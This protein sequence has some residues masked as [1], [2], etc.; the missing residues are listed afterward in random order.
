[1]KWSAPAINPKDVHIAVVDDEPIIQETIAAY[2]KNE[3]YKVSTADGATELRRLMDRR[4]FD[5]VLLDIRLSDGDGLSLMRD[6][7]A[8]SDIPVILVTSKSDETDRVIGLELGA[9]DYITK[10]FSPRE[11]LARV[12]TVLRRL[13]RAPEDPRPAAL[14]RFAGWSLHV[15][16]RRLT[17]PD[18]EQVR[19]TL[20]EFD[21]LSALV[22]HPGRVM[23][24][25]DLVETIGD[26]EWYPSDRT[27]DVLI[28]R[29]RRKIEPDP[30]RP[31]MIV[32]EYALGYV[33]AER[34]T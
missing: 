24:R 15:E 16:D 7:H 2:L 1:M 8:N 5:L 18:G 34:V 28:G 13:R 29:L 22:N 23:S 14:R 6:L 10:P 25:A 4:Q 19:L 17:N 11:L 32:T 27:I 3:G 26:R 21:L 9:D 31:T 20:A 33:F 12:H 30:S